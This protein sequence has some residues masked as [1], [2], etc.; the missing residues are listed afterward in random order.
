MKT[1]NYTKSKPKKVSA[2]G[3][4]QI[5]RFGLALGAVALFTSTAYMNI[6]SWMAQAVSPGQALA[7]GG[8]ASAFELM[9]L[10]GLSWA[11]FQFVKGRKSAAFVATAIAITAIIFNT[12][13][14]QNFL[15]LQGDFLVNGIEMS[16]QDASVA[17]AEID[18][19]QAQVDS[20]IE[21]NGGTIPRPISAIEAQYAYLD[22]ETNPI[23]M[24]RRDSEIALREEYNRLQG[25]ILEIKRDSAGAN[26]ASNDT[27]R[28]VIPPHLMTPFIY[29]IEAI[30]GTVFFAL[31][32]ASAQ[33]AKDKRKWAIIR[34]KQNTTQ[35]RLAKKPNGRFERK[36]TSGGVKK[37][38]Y[39]TS[40]RNARSQPKAPSRKPAG[41]KTFSPS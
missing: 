13:A 7:N 23:N 40:R 27:A 35:K 25:E 39:Q 19:L 28:T 4:F 15:D 29:A 11:G 9:A 17:Q 6:S 33:T 14:T 10:C 5:A 30:K 3:D 20:L 32:T 36:A 2:T 26:V 24:G 1:N 8:L 16:A 22:E 12:F 31:G 37:S 34:S 18:V 38:K 21:E 41:R